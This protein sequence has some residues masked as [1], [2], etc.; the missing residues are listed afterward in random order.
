MRQKARPLE[1]KVERILNENSSTFSEADA[2]LA[3]GAGLDRVRQ[4]PQRARPLEEKGVKILRENLSSFS[5]A[6]AC[7]AL[8]AGLDRVRQV[9]QRSSGEFE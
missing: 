1:L 2:C 6:D 3:P 5:E 8:G 9:R 4:A 7:S